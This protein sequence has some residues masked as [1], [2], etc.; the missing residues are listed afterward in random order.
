[1]LIFFP[2]TPRAGRKASQKAIVLD[3]EDERPATQSRSQRAPTDSQPR[4]LG[5]P[6]H[7]SDEEDDSE[8]SDSDGSGSGSGSD[9]SSSRRKARS[10]SEGSIDDFLAE[11]DENMEKEVEKYRADLQMKSQGMRYYYK[12]YIILL[13]YM[14]IDPDRDWRREDKELRTADEK[15]TQE[16]EG[17]L[18]SLVG[19]SAWKVRPAR[20][21]CSRHSR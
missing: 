21:S 4:F 8:E 13:V 12:T 20:M 1:L 7:N 18:S 5:D 9:S 15:V 11:D 6:D 10:D 3:S 16:L 19:S 14:I 2:R 17:F